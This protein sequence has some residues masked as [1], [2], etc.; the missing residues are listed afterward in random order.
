VR[1]FDL[2]V[3]LMLAAS[4]LVALLVWNP[5]PYYA[6][7]ND[8]KESVALRDYALT[9][10][11][12]MGLVW[13][14]TQPPTAVCRAFASASNLTLV[15]T[16]DIGSFS[17][18]PQPGPGEATASFTLVLGGRTMVVEDWYTGRA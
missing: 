7:A 12:N 6:A 3:A 10:V 17:C 15:L 1:L 16:A 18:G 9:T 2:T 11:E 5:A 8:T 4:S 14:Q 13:L